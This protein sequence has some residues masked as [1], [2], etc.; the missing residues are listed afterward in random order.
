MKPK[1]LNLDEIYE[2]YGLFYVNKPSPQDLRR[3][4]GIL[5][6]NKV[7]LFITPDDV[8]SGIVAGLYA[9]GINEFIEFIKRIS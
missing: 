2:I 3:I 4:V 1:K 8:L 7:Q 6:P 9:N 5:Y